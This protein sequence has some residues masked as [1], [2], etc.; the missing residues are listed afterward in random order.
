MKR[1]E[2]ATRGGGPAVSLED[3]GFAGLGAQHWNDTQAVLAE[4]ALVRGEG[5][6]TRPGGPGLPDGQVHRAFPEG[7]VHRP[8]AVRA[9]S[10]S[11]GATVNQ[12]FEPSKFDALEA[13][14]REH[15]RGREVWVQDAFGG[16]DPTHRLPIRVVCERA[17]HA[18]FARQ[19]F[20]RP[21]PSEL[22]EHRPEFT[23]VAAPDFLAVP[24]RDG[25]RSE[26]F[27]LLNFAE[28]ARPDRRDAVRGRDQEVGLHRS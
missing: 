11:T 20:V 17:Y 8:R 16:T 4:H 22:A 26:V 21:E 9:R 13:R 28:T 25:T 15:L 3:Q 27:I 18:L 5:K 14:V 23:I 2:D 7:Q 12:P 10:T 1:A 19:L 6:L 24:E